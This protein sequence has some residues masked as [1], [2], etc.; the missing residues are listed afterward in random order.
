[1]RRL[2]ACRSTT[3]RNLGCHPSARCRVAEHAHSPF[4]VKC[5]AAAVNVRVSARRE[6]GGPQHR[7]SATT[8][9]SS[10]SAAGIVGR[11]SIRLVYSR[12]EA[13]CAAGQM[14]HRQGAAN[15]AT[16]LGAALLAL[17]AD[18]D[19]RAGRFT[20]KA[21]SQAL[22]VPLST[23]YRLLNSLVAGG[24]AIRNLDDGLYRLGSRVA[25]LHQLPHR[26]AATARCPRVRPRPATGNGRDRDFRLDRGRQSGGLGG[27]RGDPSW[28]ASARLCRFRG[29]RARDGGESAPGCVVAAQ[30]EAYLLSRRNRLW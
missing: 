10:G 19:P 24:S 8:F 12:L 4:I 17:L 2:A 7:H 26:A 30:L 16:R 6:V 25:Y 3:G 14:G 23:C 1:V 22:G 20:P 21:L 13:R 29:A 27:R 9:A 28:H 18:P 11:E 5:E 15:R